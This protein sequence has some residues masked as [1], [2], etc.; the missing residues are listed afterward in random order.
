MKLKMDFKREVVKKLKKKIMVR[1]DFNLL[2]LPATL[3][4][5]I[6]REYFKP[7]LVIY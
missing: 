1:Q 7:P 6:P 2:I 5:A 4:D 3:K